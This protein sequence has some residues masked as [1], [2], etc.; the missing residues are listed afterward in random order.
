MKGEEKKLFT[1][2]NSQEK[3]FWLW[4]ELE[5]M[6]HYTGLIFPS[7]YIMES[8]GNNK[9]EYPI[10]TDVS[11]QIRNDHL[12]YA[13]TWYSAAIASAVIYILYYRKQ[14]QG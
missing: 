7:F 10:G 9:G 12:Q 1:P 14:K 2:K 8:L 6:Q 4:V 3:N 13:I 5:A 11:L